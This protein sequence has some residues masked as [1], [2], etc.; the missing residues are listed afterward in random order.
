MPKSYSW[1]VP[2]RAG[3]QEIVADNPF[4]SVEISVTVELKEKL[5]GTIPNRKQ[6]FID[7]IADKMGDFQGKP[8]KT[9]EEYDEEVATVPKEVSDAATSFHSDT[10]GIYIYNYMLLGNIK[11]NIFC[12]MANGV[13]KVLHYKKTA[14]LF[15]KVFPRKIRFIKDDDST[16]FEPDGSFERSMRVDTIKG[17][18]TFIAKSFY[19]EK[20]TRLKFNV[21][22]YRN[23]RGLTPEVV[24]NAL[25][26]GKENG[27][28]QW[29]GSGNFGQYKIL[30][31]KYVNQK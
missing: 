31:L 15:C 25:K 5:L 3:L 2:T 29:R 10:F 9:I 13:C 4:E 21:K 24:V 8:L 27:L 26:F 16:L 7:H 14:D 17:P 23:D 20:K 22:I 28:G 11:S 12:I 18:R 1:N 6:V 19:V 30:S